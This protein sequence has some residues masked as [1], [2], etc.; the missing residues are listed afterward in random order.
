MT[1]LIKSLAK[2]LIYLTLFIIIKN[3]MADKYLRPPT[4]EHRINSSDYVINGDVVD[5]RYAHIDFK[6]NKYR[7]VSDG[8]MKIPGN[9]LVVVYNIDVKDAVKWP[10]DKVLPKTVLL[11][12]PPDLHVKTGDVRLWFLR[13]SVGIK[14][15]VRL[16]GKV[17]QIGY[18]FAGD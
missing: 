2:I 7:E 8:R 15:F 3:V 9:F 4:L 10:K 14:S 13:P 18:Q 5:V 11:P 16:D 1:N 12:T 17:E 6:S